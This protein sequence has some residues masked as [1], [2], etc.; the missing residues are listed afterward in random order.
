MQV[1]MY[2]HLCFSRIQ[3]TTY[4]SKS[5]KYQGSFIWDNMEFGTKSDKSLKL[6]Y[7]DIILQLIQTYLKVNIL[8]H[9][10]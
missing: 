6:Q 1:S 9:V 3:T 4:E 8:D 10:V 5:I 2:D 7:T